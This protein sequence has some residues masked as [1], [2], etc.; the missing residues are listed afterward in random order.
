M[1]IIHSTKKKVVLKIFCNIPP[2]FIV[3]KNR[4]GFFLKHT[5]TFSGVVNTFKLRTTVINV[6]LPQILLFNDLCT[7]S[8]FIIIAYQKYFHFF[9]VYVVNIEITQ[10]FSLPDIIKFIQ[11][12]KTL[13]IVFDRVAP[14][15][16]PLD[17]LVVLFSV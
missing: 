14:L 15:C 5:K 8:E 12:L 9:F 11:N 6:S 17:Y 2:S 7:D 1:C 10:N 16:Y 4:I 3:L 13:K